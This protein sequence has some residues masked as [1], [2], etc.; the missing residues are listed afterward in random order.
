M[1]GRNNKHKAQAFR[2]RSRESSDHHAG[3]DDD[4][5]CDTQDK[6]SGSFP[7]DSLKETEEYQKR[8]EIDGPKRKYAVRMVSRQCRIKV[9]VIYIFVVNVCT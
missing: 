9:G 8:I 3:D 5:V 4:D 1:K 2:K 6:R 7:L